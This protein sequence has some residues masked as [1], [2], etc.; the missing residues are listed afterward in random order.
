MPDFKVIPLAGWPPEVLA[1]GF[2]RYSRSDLSILEMLP[3]IF[4]QRNEVEF[5]ERV[6]FNYGHASV[7][8][9]AH[10]PIA[11]EGIPQIAAFEVE[12]QQLWDGQERSTRYQDFRR[13]GDCFVIPRD[14]KGTWGEGRYV[15]FAEFLLQEYA[16]F[17]QACFEYFV[18]TNPKP[19]N[20]TA[21]AYESALRARALD[22]ARYWLF[23][24]IKTSVGQITSARVLEEQ[25]TRLMSSEYPDVRE[26]GAAMKQAC[27]EKPFS[28]E[29]ED[30]P[31]VAPTLVKYAAESQYMCAMRSAAKRFYKELRH[32]WVDSSWPRHTVRLCTPALLN[33]EIVASILY[34]ACQIPY[35]AILEAVQT[36]LPEKVKQEILQTAFE[37]R[38]AH[39]PL[40]RPYASGYQ[41]MFD[42]EM[43]RGGERDL[44]RHRNCIQLHKPLTVMSGYDI[45]AV[46]NDMR[47]VPRFIEGMVKVR[48]VVSELGK[49]FG[50][51]ADFL[52]PFAYLSSTLYKMSLSEAIYIIELR[53]KP[54]GHFSYR[55]VVE[56]MHDALVGRYPFLEGKVRLVPFKEGDLL[57][58]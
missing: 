46:L 5:L 21:V 56:E 49:A 25:L 50:P 6:R 42:I 30:H 19:A 26:I 1:Y 18:K 23:G 8:D 35:E 31:P 53:S 36:R 45:P 2:A 37:L 16:F 48:A 10:V 40:P 52:I 11:L 4:N 47:L 54:G 27:S 28:P 9:N 51:S 55:K 39:D 14:I 41:I 3:Q 20:M 7:A 29:G 15:E 57:K 58:R 33:D 22:I 43:D 24:G 34:E 32:H 17:S 12:D 44:H 13:G 38:G